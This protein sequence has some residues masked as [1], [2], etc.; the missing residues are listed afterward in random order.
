[1]DADKDAP[2]LDEPP[3]EEPPIEEPPAVD[4]TD[5][6][7]ETE[8]PLEEE[9]TG[10]ADGNI[11]EQ[12]QTND[13]PTLSPESEAEPPLESQPEDTQEPVDGHEEESI[14]S[15]NSTEIQ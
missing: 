3:T 1:M 13:E 8:I 12:T 2:V 5:P 14:D 11:N 15:S 7:P 6:T 4:G 9:N 10:A